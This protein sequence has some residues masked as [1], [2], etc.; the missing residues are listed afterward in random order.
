MD[1]VRVRSAIRDTDLVWLFDGRVLEVF[2][3]SADVARY[4]VALMGL[5]AEGPDR[6]N[7]YKV[8]IDSIAGTSRGGM[9]DIVDEAGFELLRPLLK[10]VNDAIELASGDALTPA[11]D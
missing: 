8:S 10:R 7:R 1:E 5:K 4:H 9:N 2:G 3:M 6:G 11:P